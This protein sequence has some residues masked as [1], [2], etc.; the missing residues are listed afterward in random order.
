MRAREGPEVRCHFD[1][2]GKCYTSADYYEY[3]GMFL[4][5]RGRTAEFG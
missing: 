4:A 1:I 3:G 5:C 2:E